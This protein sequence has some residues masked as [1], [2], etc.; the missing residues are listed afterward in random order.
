MVLRSLASFRQYNVDIPF[1][2][3]T[4]QRELSADVLEAFPRV[5]TLEEAVPLHNM[6]KLKALINSP[7]QRTVIVDPG[8]MFC[9]D[10]LGIF[11]FVDNFDLAAPFVRDDLLYRTAR[12][13]QMENVALHMR[14][15]QMSTLSSKIVLVKRTPRSDRF[16]QDWYVALGRTT[17]RNDDFWLGHLLPRSDVRFIS[18]P[19]EYGIVV[20]PQSRLPVPV[21]G[22]VLVY[23]HGIESTAPPLSC[24]VVN[25]ITEPRLVFPDRAEV[26]SVN[27]LSV[28]Y[29][30]VAAGDIV[31][32]ADD[33]LKN[34]LKLGE[35][36]IVP[37]DS[38]LR[39]TADAAENA[40]PDVS[41]EKKALPRELDAGDG[42]VAG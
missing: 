4:D 13:S 26:V 1:M 3:A 29:Q 7:F 39:K 15:A 21:M 9:H 14:E 37:I 8:I 31:V 5:M 24:S 18:L 27:A 28:T 34:E 10:V 32:R 23:Y 33:A 11:Q 17:A 12:V 19:P 16:L 35:N 20:R 42:D 6:Q 30:A 36:A 41:N 40:L 22:R 38:R 2:L 25:S